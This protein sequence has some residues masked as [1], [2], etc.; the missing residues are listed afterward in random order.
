MAEKES[1]V[2]ANLNASGFLGGVA[3][4]GAATKKFAKEAKHEIREGFHEGL[5]EASNELRETGR[6]MRGLLKTALGI[7]GAFSL[8]EGIRGANEMKGQMAGIADRL[9]DMT[10]KTVSWEEASARVVSSAN[11]A[12]QPIEK[13]GEA[14]DDLLQKTGDAAFAD[15]TLDFIGK[16]AKA[17]RQST[18]TVTE[19]VTVMKE[20]FEASAKEVPQLLADMFAETRKGGA[21]FAE[22][23]PLMSQLG[24]TA[25]QAGLDGTRSFRFLLGALKE[26]HEGMGSV[27]K[28]A[29]GI[30]DM[31]ARLA[32]QSELL[33]QIAKKAN[34]SN[35]AKFAKE[36][37]ASAD[38][39]EVMQKVLAHTKGYD[40]LHAAMGKAKS[41]AKLAF[42]LLTKPFNDS[43]A[44]V[45]DNTHATEAQKKAAVQQGLDAFNKFVLGFGRSD[46]TAE[47]VL[48]RFGKKSASAEANLTLAMNKFKAAFVD[49]RMMAAITKLS[50]SLPKLADLVAKVAGFVVEHPGKA[51]AGYVG[52]KVGGAVGAAVG[53][54][55]LKKVL[56]RG[57]AAAAGEAL[58]GEGAA[59]GAA[60]AGTLAE[61]TG[62]V[63]G[64]V[65][66]AKALAGLGGA[67]AAAGEGA[68]AGGGLLST[69]GAAIGGSALATAG[70]GVVAGGSLLAAGDQFRRLKKESG[71]EG[72]WEGL[73]TALKRSFGFEKGTGTSREEYD[74]IYPKLEEGVENATDAIVKHI[75][76]TDD[77]AQSLK[78]VS[79]EA[80]RL[81]ASIRAA[82]D[83]IDSGGSASVA[84]PNNPTRGPVRLPTPTPGATPMPFNR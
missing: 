58:A 67:G 21:S 39:L 57:A 20:K 48:D 33:D 49:P 50:A 16:F 29:A 28:Q 32:P 7:G 40:A 47:A 61:A 9:S 66:G 13:I 65:A 22:L 64:L 35:P 84:V 73:T 80:N 36:L 42:E 56:S 38:A 72:I 23:T 17:E 25:N 69:A 51:A 59:V 12:R 31:L 77:S 26:T 81:A 68:A 19:A 62:G 55:V 78:K 41:P 74:E 1:T 14:Y 30:G 6:E 76:V 46:L 5:K 3:Q 53:A 63:A 71:E 10:G 24:A 2:R 15:K 44:E 8:E 52:L 11:A 70:L 45:L 83:A 60:G 27:E 18:E 4:M 54:A 34:P 79:T 43:A 37:H 75:S 82:S